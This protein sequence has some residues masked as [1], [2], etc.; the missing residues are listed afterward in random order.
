MEIAMDRTSHLQ[1]SQYNFSR[2]MALNLTPKNVIGLSVALL[3]LAAIFG[4]LNAQKTKSLRQSAAKAINSRDELERRHAAEQ[5]ELKTRE[6]TV[7]GA[8]SKLT[9]NESKVAKAE[10]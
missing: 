3:G 2:P 7:A 4:L 10:A 5:K 8:M 9:D 6:A 1:T